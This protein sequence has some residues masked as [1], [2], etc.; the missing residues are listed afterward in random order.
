MSSFRT[1][2]RWHAVFQVQ[3]CVLF[4]VG[5]LCLLLTWIFFDFFRGLSWLD[6][7]AWL[8]LAVLLGI[9]A[10]LMSRQWASTLLSLALVLA[11]LSGLAYL[12]LGIGA[13]ALPPSLILTGAIILLLLLNGGVI[14]LTRRVQRD[15]RQA[16]PPVQR[17]RR[18]FLGLLTRTS[19]AV[20]LGGIFIKAYLWDDPSR[21]WLL[22]DLVRQES[23]KLTLAA[24]EQ[25]QLTD[26]SH[27]NSSRVAEIRR[28]ETLAEVIKAVKDAQAGQRKISLSGIRHSMGGQALGLNTLH[29]DMTHLDSVHYNMDNQTVTVG[30]GATW[31]QIQEVLS[32][33]GRAVMVMQD[34][35]IFSV[36]GSLSVNA[37]GK[38]PRYGSLIESVNFIKLLGA[39]GQEVFCDRTQNQ[40]LFTAA[41]GGFGLFGIITE[42]NLQTTQNTYFAFSLKSVPTHAV[43]DN[44]EI[45]S[46]N[47]ANRLLEAHLSVDAEH[48]LTESLIFTYTETSS[49]Q[50]PGDELDGENSIWLRKVV[51]QASRASNFGKYF[52]WEMEKY[53]SPLVEPASISRNTAMAVPVR[54]LQN[55]DPHSTDILQ[56]YFVPIERS[57]AF[58]ATYKQLLKKYQIDLLNVTIRRVKQD[59]SALVS[60]AQQDM[61]GFVVYY[62]IRQNSPDIPTLQNFTRELIDYLISI[63]ARY[64]LCY[65]GYYTPAQLT[66]MYPTIKT[67]FALKARHDPQQLFTSIWYEHYYRSIS[68]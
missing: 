46:K 64:Y 6:G 66:S 10:L 32:P 11:T 5:S 49:A 54:F 48:F 19:L 21:Q 13:L 16:V 30:P 27:L 41:I 29:L 33:H 65:G 59:T 51:F 7:Y 2:S 28:P 57:N 26:A 63:Q 4:S 22:T 40:E 34:S 38:D 35:N 24:P 56:E 44:L 67:L 68:S 36:G 50:Q 1:A 60:Y 43:I 39:D 62:K 42:I 8:P 17:Q 20:A 18:S 15:T 37:H 45:L 52:R 3:M 47:P 53:V 58:L 25:L 31:E 14:Y 61:Y 9:L 12:L 23:H 55:P